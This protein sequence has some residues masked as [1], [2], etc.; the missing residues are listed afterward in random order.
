M[1]VFML[2]HFLYSCTVQDPLHREW[3]HPQWTGLPR[4]SNAITDMPT[5]Q[6]NLDN[7]SLKSFSDD[8]RPRQVDINANYHGPYD[9]KSLSYIFR[10]RR[11]D[12]YTRLEAEVKH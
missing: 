11:C 5:C 3:C 6:P 4:L 12:Y 7:P 9:L 2:S 8:S 1:N 10:E